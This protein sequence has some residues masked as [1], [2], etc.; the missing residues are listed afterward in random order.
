MHR[1]RAT[2]IGV[3]QSYR[4]ANLLIC[5]A[6]SPMVS[7]D[8]HDFFCRR[9]TIPRRR[10]RAHW[11][12]RASSAVTHFTLTLRQFAHALLCRAV[13][14]VDC[15]PCSSPPGAGPVAFCRFLG[16][17][18]CSREAPP[19]PRRWFMPTFVWCQIG[20]EPCP[21]GTY[22]YRIPPIPSVVSKR[23]LGVLLECRCF[24]ELCGA[25]HVR[26][27]PTR[28]LWVRGYRVQVN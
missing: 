2:H 14:I 22:H 15:V 13:F 10:Q 7:P 9:Q 26:G 27:P 24:A 8:V 11:P 4:S 25:Q 6:S 28:T 16:W 1:W 12:E 20:R 18:G 19:S 21:S 23:A 3:P 5:E 17:S